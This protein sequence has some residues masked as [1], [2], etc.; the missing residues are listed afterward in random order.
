MPILAIP[1]S[2]VKEET[3]HLRAFKTGSSGK[4][5]EDQEK[6]RERLEDSPLPFHNKQ[7]HEDKRGTGDAPCLALRRPVAACAVG[8]YGGGGW[9]VGGVRG[10]G[11]RPGLEAA[12]SIPP[13]ACLTPHGGRVRLNGS[14]WPS[15]PPL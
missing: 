14:T 8:M 6:K 10:R 12:G 5:R 9:G 1:H 11:A 3:F 15:T 13:R 4:E 2:E 7:K